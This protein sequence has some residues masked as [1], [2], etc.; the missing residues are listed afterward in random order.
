MGDVTLTRENAH[1]F[2]ATFD[3]EIS[4]IAVFKE[5]GHRVVETLNWLNQ[6][7]EALLIDLDAQLENI[8]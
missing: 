2:G 1:Q 7:V 6:S 8:L 3:G 4:N 5:N